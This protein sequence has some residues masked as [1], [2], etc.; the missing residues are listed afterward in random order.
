MLLGAGHDVVVFDSLELGH[1][2]AV[3]PRASLLVGDLRER[4]DIDSAV[5]TVAPDAAM[6]FA[7]YAL[8]GESMTD[9][10]R[11][12]ANNVTGGLNLADAMLRHGVRRIVFSSSCATYG[13]PER[14]PISEDTPQRPTNPYGESKLVLERALTWL[15]RRR[16]L[17]PTFL[18][19]FNACGAE[20]GLGEDHDP[21]TH[22]I[23]NVLRTALGLQPAVNLYGTDYPTPDGTCVRDYVHVT[24]LAAAHVAAVE[25]GVAGAF[26]LGSGAGASVREVLA[27]C[28]RVCGRPIAVSER[29]R[30][31]G[32][33][34]VLVATHEKA[35]QQLGWEPVRSS[36]DRIVADAWQWHRS[37][38]HGYGEV[39]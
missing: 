24:D 27:A 31:P 38:P 34:P 25:R 10:L 18:R 4:G 29:E 21:E 11:Y 20:D 16:G 8:V 22:L 2:E 19:Y 1:R 32:D 13:E 36:L 14:M 12:F 15:E 7:A 35:R 39:F 3:D 23:P 6:H 33:P 17:V 37:H 26:N 30:R 5:R 28:E 9:P